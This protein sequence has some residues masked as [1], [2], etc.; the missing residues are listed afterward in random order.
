MGLKQRPKHTVPFL[1]LLLLI[2]PVDVKTKEFHL[3]NHKA[4]HPC[5]LVKTVA[6]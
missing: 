6:R 2:Y 5:L 1:L 3:V 4:Y